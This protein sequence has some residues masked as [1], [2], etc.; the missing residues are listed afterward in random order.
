MRLGRQQIPDV[1]RGYAPG[2]ERRETFCREGVRVQRHKGIGG[3]DLFKRVVQRQKAGQ[4]RCV[5]DERGP[6]YMPLLVIEF[7]SRRAIYDL[8]LLESTARLP[9][10]MAVEACDSFHCR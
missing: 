4:I 8:P 3:F 6:D 7:T 5:G 2:C 10:A 9:S 1:L